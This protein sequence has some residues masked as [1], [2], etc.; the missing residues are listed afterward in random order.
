MLRW[1]HDTSHAR[2]VRPLLGWLHR[3]GCH[4]G[5]RERLWR[6]RIGDDRL[7]AGGEKKEWKA[8]DRK[9]ARADKEDIEARVGGG[10][11]GG[12]RLRM[13]QQVAADGGSAMT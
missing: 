4:G 13:D 12:R 10:R 1:D 6:G 2:L 7:G 8:G 5:S 9:D 3:P 11:E